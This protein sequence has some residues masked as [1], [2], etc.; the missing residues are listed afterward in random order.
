[1]R[2]PLLCAAVLAAVG[3]LVGGCQS[4]RT[5]EGPG[6][7]TVVAGPILPVH[8]V[9]S[10][11]APPPSTP[12]T[13]TRSPAALPVSVRIPSIGAKSTLLPLGLNPDGSVQVPPVSTP[14]QAGWYDGGAAPGEP[15]PAVLLGHVDGDR[16]A[17]IFFRL[18]ELT[19]GA[20]V[21]VTRA[22][23]TVVT[24]AVTKVTEVAKNTFPTDAVYGP[25]KDPELRLVTCGGG[26]DSATHSYLDNVIVFA[27]LV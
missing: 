8:A 22:D 5:A 25:T 23:G 11:P 1:V 6:R 14:L 21:T 2:I 18:H 4:D 19:P 17:G 16:Q 10:G 7:Q 9:D 3:L 24:F 20:R 15:G 12:A 13:L 26:F 27:A